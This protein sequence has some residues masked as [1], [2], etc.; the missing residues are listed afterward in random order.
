MARSRF[1]T[2]GAHS[3]GHEVL[4][5]L[6]QEGVRDSV[7]R[8]KKLLEEWTGK[9]IQHFAYPHGLFTPEIAHIV[10]ECG[11][12]SSQSTRPGLWRKGDS[13]FAIPRVPVG[14]Y[15]S[16]ALF[17]MRVSGMPGW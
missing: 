14:R 16:L 12:V 3:H 5:Q 11:F 10:Q 13:D 8:S 4:P 1:V 15:D 9:P 6:S 2:F 7:L 17:R